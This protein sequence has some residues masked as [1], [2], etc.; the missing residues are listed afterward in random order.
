MVGWHVKPW[1]LHLNQPETI[2]YKDLSS[3]TLNI[4]AYI[5]NS[6]SKYLNGKI[7]D[8]QLYNSEYL[9]TIIGRTDIYS[10]LLYYIP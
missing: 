10:N 7:A 5:T 9:N 6:D 3:S 2:I 4:G 8:L 1:W